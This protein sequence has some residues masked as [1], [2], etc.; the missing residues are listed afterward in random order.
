[1]QTYDWILPVNG[2]KG[3]IMWVLLFEFLDYERQF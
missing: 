1:M 3:A 2:Y